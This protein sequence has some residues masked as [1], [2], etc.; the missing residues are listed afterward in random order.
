VSTPKHLQEKTFHFFF[1]NYR[2]LFVVIF[3][4]LEDVTHRTQIP[5]G[6]LTARTCLRLVSA[7]DCRILRGRDPALMTKWGECPTI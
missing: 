1:D 4:A 2:R 5:A 3:K 6:L 7:V